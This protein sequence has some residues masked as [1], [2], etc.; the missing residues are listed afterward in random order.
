MR[1]IQQQV[2]ELKELRGIKRRPDLR[3]VDKDE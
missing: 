2:D 3:L 1:G